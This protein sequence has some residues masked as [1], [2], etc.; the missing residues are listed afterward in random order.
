LWV[1]VS[2]KLQRAHASMCCRDVGVG[3]TTFAKYLI[4]ALTNVPL[5]AIVS[6]TF[7]IDIIYDTKD[8]R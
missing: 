4:K 1:D 7:T 8:I 3:K 6:P 2:L 5:R